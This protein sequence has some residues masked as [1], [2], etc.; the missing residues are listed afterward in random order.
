MALARQISGLEGP[1]APGIP[2]GP[3]NFSGDFPLTFPPWVKLL[4]GPE[5]EFFASNSCTTLPL[6]SASAPEAHFFI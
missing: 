1:Y 5:K 2:S 6:H 3:I 4:M